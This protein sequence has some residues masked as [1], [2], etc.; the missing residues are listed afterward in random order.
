MSD[1]KDLVDL[2]GGVNNETEH[3]FEAELDYEAYEDF[4]KTLRE[5][6]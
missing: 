1:P 6:E 4:L 3:D 2:L 5:E